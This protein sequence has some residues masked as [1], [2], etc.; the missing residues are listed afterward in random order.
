MRKKLPRRLLVLARELDAE[1]S[2][3]ARNCFNV[4]P[5]MAVPRQSDGSRTRTDCALTARGYRCLFTYRRWLD[6]LGCN[7]GGHVHIVDGLGWLRGGRSVKTLRPICVDR[8]IYHGTHAAPNVSVP[9]IGL[10][11]IRLPLAD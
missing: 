9:R 6:E 4:V 5:E 2:G 3:I 1:W 10:P 8:A 7:V 11:Y